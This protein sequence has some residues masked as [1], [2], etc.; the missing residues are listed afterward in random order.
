[1]APYRIWLAVGLSP[2][3]GPAESAAKAARDRLFRLC[4]PK[5]N[6]EAHVHCDGTLHASATIRAATPD[7]ALRMGEGAVE[8]ALGYKPSEWYAQRVQI[9]SLP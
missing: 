4:G 2:H 9:G 3:G 6:A 7:A 1:M 8:A 5:G